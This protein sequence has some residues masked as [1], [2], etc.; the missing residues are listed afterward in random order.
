MLSHHATCVICVS[1][2][3]HM[4]RKLGQ[5]DGLS[6]E[7]K[8]TSLAVR[9]PQPSRTRRRPT[10][11][12]VKT[13]VLDKGSSTSTGNVTSPHPPSTLTLCHTRR[14]ANVQTPTILSAHVVTSSRCH[15]Q[16]ARDQTGLKRLEDACTPAGVAKMLIRDGDKK[17][18]VNLTGPLVHFKRRTQSNQTLFF[19]TS[20]VASRRQ[21][22]EALFV[23]KIQDH[24]KNEKTNRLRWY[25]E[26]ECHDRLT[27]DPRT[28]FRL[29]FDLGLCYGFNLPFLSNRQVH[30]GSEAVS[31][32]SR[33]Q[34]LEDREAA[35]H[36]C[37]VPGPFRSSL[38]FSRPSRRSPPFA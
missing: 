32:P 9:L 29:D 23:K 33:R 8:R 34:I 17:D 2:I 31:G 16:V 4:Q 37:R 30:L 13:K 7:C 5:G 3:S 28:Q 26:Q 36:Q 27:F 21:L 22:K 20:P 14:A 6:A 11:D 1:C 25:V 18:G 38:P 24:V 10:E 12:G 35:L 19:F 15:L